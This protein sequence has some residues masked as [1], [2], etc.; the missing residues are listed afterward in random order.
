MFG[1]LSIFPLISLRGNGLWNSKSSNKDAEVLIV[2]WSQTTGL[3]AHKGERRKSKIDNWR[4]PAL[5]KSAV[6]RSSFDATERPPPMAFVRS[7]IH[8]NSAGESDGSSATSDTKPSARV[9]RLK[10]RGGFARILGIIRQAFLSWRESVRYS[11]S[12]ILRE[13]AVVNLSRDHELQR[14]VPMRS[15]ARI[16]AL[17]IGLITL[18]AFVTDSANAFDYVGDLSAKIKPTRGCRLQAGRRSRVASEYLRA[19]RISAE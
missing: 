15:K 3:P 16:V 6:D 1:M 5:A 2:A 11:E 7:G 4:T 9:V 17:S 19:G 8:K 13:T 14:E 10:L 12:S 18:V